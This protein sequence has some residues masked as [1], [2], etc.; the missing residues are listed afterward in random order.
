[1][2]LIQISNFRHWQIVHIKTNVFSFCFLHFILE[3]ITGY[4]SFLI[5]HKNELKGTYVL[6]NV[7][8]TFVVFSV[9]HNKCP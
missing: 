2:S 5:N 8:Y 4:T 3:K 6:N 9:Y 1:M 7:N